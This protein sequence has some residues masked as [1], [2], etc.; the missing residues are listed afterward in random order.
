MS[1]PAD[2]PL[3]PS[4]ISVSIGT[5]PVSARTPSTAVRCRKVAQRVA[6]GPLPISPEALQ[7]SGPELWSKLAVRY[8][9]WKARSTASRVGA[10]S[11]VSCH[12][13]P[14]P[15]VMTWPSAATSAG[16]GTTPTVRNGWFCSSRNIREP[17]PSGVTGP[18]S[19]TRS[20]ARTRLPGRDRSPSA[21][22]R[23]RSGRSVR[24]GCVATAV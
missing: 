14:D 17:R 1:L 23:A 24:T 5:A 2:W 19:P 7:P 11:S 13:P 6:Y 22:A 18:A 20:A 3:P 21:S 8:W 4:T 16:E 9:A 10:P 12:A 15:E